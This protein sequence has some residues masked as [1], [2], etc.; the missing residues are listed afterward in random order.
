MENILA[1]IHKIEEKDPIKAGK[2]SSCVFLMQSLTQQ[3]LNGPGPF[4][5]CRVKDCIRKTQCDIHK[6]AKQ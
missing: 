2:K 5:N 4:N 6:G 1:Y 3:L